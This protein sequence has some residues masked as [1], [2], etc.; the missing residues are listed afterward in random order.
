M[1]DEVK[2]A[3]LARGPGKDRPAQAAPGCAL[4][5]VCFAHM[6]EPSLAFFAS[7][8]KGKIGSEKGMHRE[9]RGRTRDSNRPGVSIESLLDLKGRRRGMSAKVS[10]RCEKNERRDG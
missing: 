8:G 5:R 6:K 10:K 1:D 3:S 7:T 2:K 4:A 9:T